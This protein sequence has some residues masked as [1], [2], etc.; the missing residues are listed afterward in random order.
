MPAPIV[1]TLY[2]RAGCSL[3]DRAEALLRG[4]EAGLGFRL[5]VVDIE[6]D[7]ELHRRY[8][9]EIPV[10]VCDGRELA[11]GR[12]TPAALEAELRALVSPGGR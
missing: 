1:V 12:V 4:L 6:G 3:C 7:E 11:R 10:V 8:L 2:T 5:A 9:F